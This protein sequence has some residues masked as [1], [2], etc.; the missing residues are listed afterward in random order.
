[1]RS[2]IASRGIPVNKITVIP[3]A[4]D[5]DQFTY[6]IEA[7]QA[8]S[9]KLGLQNKTVLGFI[10]SFYAYEGL[11]LLLD[12][13]PK[14][15]TKH[16]EIRLLLVG[17][18]PQEEFIKQK[19]KDMGLQHVVIFTGRIAHELVQDYYNQVDIFVYPRLAMRLTN[20]VTPLKPLE[21]MAQGRLV[22]ASDVG[23]HKELIKP[24]YNGFLFKANDADE[25]AK[26]V[27]DILNQTHNWQELKDVARSFVEKERNWE[28][29]V[30]FYKDVYKQL[31]DD[32]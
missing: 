5:I 1:M 7:D 23:G 22:L 4:V 31:I 10:G 25:L 3:N 12:A 18:G 6:G 13:L 30:G 29:S 9:R 11:P 19:I 17:G 16:P 28:K 26:T 14:I 15:M 21:A 27:I 32:S 24:L 20:L 8:L 2:D